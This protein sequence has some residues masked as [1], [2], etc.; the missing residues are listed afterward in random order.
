MR[1]WN[2]PVDAEALIMEADTAVGL[3]G[4]EVVAL[5]LKYGRLAQYRKTVCEAAGHE[6][7]PMILFG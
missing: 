4:V 1:Y 6:K 2:L 5:V 7:L 3:G